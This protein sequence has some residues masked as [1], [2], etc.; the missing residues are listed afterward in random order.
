[1]NSVLNPIETNE[2]VECARVESL[3][4]EQI[5]DLMRTTPLENELEN[6]GKNTNVM[7]MIATIEIIVLVAEEVDRVFER[8]TQAEV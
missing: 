2:D 8:P 3:S 1:M 5:K 7:M 4:H 6:Y